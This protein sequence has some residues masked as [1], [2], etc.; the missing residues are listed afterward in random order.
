MY[1]TIKTLYKRGLNKSEIARATK[2]DW[3]TINK[4]IK[5]IKEGKFPEKITHPSKLDIYK[6]QILNIWMRDYPE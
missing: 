3:K 1:T 5:A 4:V 6:E 2:H